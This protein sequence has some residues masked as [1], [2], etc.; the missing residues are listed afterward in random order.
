MFPF[1][2]ASLLTFSL[3]S[4]VLAAS[5]DDWRGRSI[6][7]IITDRFAQPDG[8]DPYS[9]DPGARTW[10]GGTWKSIQD[11]LDYIQNAGFTAVWI[12]P[13]HQNYQGGRTAYGDPYHGYWIAD[14]SK[15]NERFGTADDLKELS[16]ELHRRGMYLMVDVIVN[17]VMSTTIKPD[18]SM[19]MFDDAMLYHPYCPI[20]WGNVTSEQDCWLGDTTVP[21]PDLDTEN[22]TVIAG[23][24]QWAEA[25]VKEYSIDGFRIDGIHVNRDFWPTFCSKA[26]VFCMGEVYGDSI[27]EVAPWQD[28]L[29]SVLNYPMYNA[30][31]Q[32]FSMSGPRNSSVLA[33]ALARSKQQCNDTT[34]L[35]NFLEN[36]ELSRW[37]NQS[38]DPQSM[39][40]AMIFNFMSDGIPI[41][42][43]GQEQ[44]FSGGGDPYNREPLW[45]SGV[46]GTAAIICVT[47]ITQVR[48]YLVDNTDWVWQETEVL[49]TSEYGIAIM[50]G[51]V[52]SILTNIGSPPQNGTHI[53]V[54][55]PYP[56]NSVLINALT[57]R[58]WIV[59]S[60]GML[61]VEYTEGGVP[62][63]LLP[64][65]MA[66]DSG[67]C[68][69]AYLAMSRIHSLEEASSGAATSGSAVAP[70][71]VIASVLG[72]A[73]VQI[74]LFLIHIFS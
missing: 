60:G 58:Q 44:Y 26:G 42:Y 16:A 23:Y 8:A 25:L 35:G 66:W 31:V 56:V 12:S 14:A 38:V 33:E 67:L 73:C 30:I 71:I 1:L 55:S 47:H 18:Y 2:C 62:V 64:E 41:M 57:C 70:Y 63:V 39:Y 22:P 20:Q 3:V 45:E 6:Y 37:H 59:G 28:A 9:C 74:L 61:N 24:G 65:L 4:P 52:I 21:L 48:N 32:T 50:K 69:K 68:H 34:L 17:N 46:S 29:D 11:N 10:C 49:T 43:Y 53:S 7:Q 15:L 27:D 36:H 51:D 13:V 72:T 54:R 40:N 19:Y 5:A